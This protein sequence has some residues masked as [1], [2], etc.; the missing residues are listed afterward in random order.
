MNGLPTI[1][2]IGACESVIR[3]TVFSLK[4]DSKNDN[5][6]I[7][8]G[9]KDIEE[10]MEVFRSFGIEVVY[11]DINIPESVES[12]LLSVS[13]VFL[14]PANDDNKVI[15]CATIINIAKKCN[16]EHFVF[17]SMIGTDDNEIEFNNQYKECENIIQQSGLD[18]TILRTNFIQELLLIFPKEIGNGKLRLPI[19]GAKFAPVSVKDVGEAAC[20]I[21]LKNGSKYEN[22]IITISGDVL[23]TGEDVARTLSKVIGNKVTFEH[24][25]KEETKRNLMKQLGYE[26]WRAN[27]I[28]HCYHT[29]LKGGYNFL[30][31][32]NKKVLGRDPM[33]LEK[34]ANCHK[35]HYLKHVDYDKLNHIILAK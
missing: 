10:S 28:I 15:E 5:Y 19:D 7:K 26:E 12:C 4:R 25:T 35:H 1:L 20:N 16:V 30:S 11:C 24:C 27:A 9:V 3:E 17:L 22:Q 23:I 33:S 32:D 2:V 29:L 34:I 18:Y 21:L 14:I 31:E 13:S 6:T 8:A